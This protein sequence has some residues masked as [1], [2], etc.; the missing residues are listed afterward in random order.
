ML[1]TR[2]FLLAAT[3]CSSLLLLL[4]L[5]PPPPPPPPPLLLLLLPLLLL[6]GSRSWWKKAPVTCSGSALAEP[7]PAISAPPV[8]LVALW[9]FCRFEGAQ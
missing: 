6:L 7:A 3:R 2:C 1:A 9:R 5:P 4:L 8:L